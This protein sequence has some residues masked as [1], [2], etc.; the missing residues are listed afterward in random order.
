M[1]L[2]VII[3]RAKYFVD[4]LNDDEVHVVMGLARRKYNPEIPSATDY[5]KVGIWRE[6]ITKKD[7]EQKIKKIY[8]LCKSYEHD[9]AKPEDYNI[10][11]THNPR[12][13]HKALVAFKS[14]LA[15]YDYDPNPSSLIHFT[16][17]WFSNLQG[18]EGRSRKLSF[19][20]DVDT[21]DLAVLDEIH[22]KY[23]VL[24]EVETRNGFHIIIE[25]Q[26][27]DVQRTPGQ[28]LLKGYDNVEVGYDRLVYLGRIE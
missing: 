11:I 24:F 22:N 23:K 13:P 9:I 25:P 5:R 8:T 10:Y 14:F 4:Q 7:Y 19:C 21:K 2:Q 27:L 3:D 6:I 28:T 26:M 12:S 16:S 17:E 1:T 20:L 18:P 15:R